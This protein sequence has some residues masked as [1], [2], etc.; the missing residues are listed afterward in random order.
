[1]REV[2]T[3]RN[4]CVTCVEKGVKKPLTASASGFCGNHD[5]ALAEKRRQAGAM[6]RPTS[7]PPRIDEPGAIGEG[8]PPPPEPESEMPTIRGTFVAMAAVDRQMSE[9]ARGVRGGKDLELVKLKLNALGKR[10]EILK[11]TLNGLQ[12]ERKRQDDLRN[13]G[14]E[15]QRRAQETERQAEEQ[16]RKNAPPGPTGQGLIAGMLSSGSA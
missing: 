8:T 13:L 11:A 10:K 3:P 4:P 6:R 1:M 2:G 16:A 12:A 14:E 7:P 15:A 9:I 5:P